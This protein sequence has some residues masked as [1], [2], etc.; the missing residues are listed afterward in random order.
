MRGKRGRCLKGHEVTR[1]SQQKTKSEKQAGTTS[2]RNW[3]RGQ[4]KKDSGGGGA[5]G[6]GGGGERT[7]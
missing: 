1:I 6:Q 5:F 3:G 7:G 4:E 2:F